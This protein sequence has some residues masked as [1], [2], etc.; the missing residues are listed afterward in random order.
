MEGDSLNTNTQF[1]NEQLKVPR[2]GDI[3]GPVTRGC[4]TKTGP[5]R[6]ALCPCGAMLGSGD[7]DPGRLTPKTEACL[8][9][10]LMCDVSCRSPPM[11]WAWPPSLGWVTEQV[12]L[13]GFVQR[14][15]W[16]RGFTRNMWGQSPGLPE[17]LSPREGVGGSSV[18]A[19]QMYRCQDSGLVPITAGEGL[20][21]Q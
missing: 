15:E 2:R 9:L 21:T 3:R 8:G 12:V 18:G 16:C 6:P 13:L 20:Q 7:R 19:T 10:Q 17:S 14:A 11:P 1:N 4:R 5:L